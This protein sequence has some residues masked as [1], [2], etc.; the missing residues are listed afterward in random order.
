MSMRGLRSTA[1]A[2][3]CLVALQC[4]PA[5]ADEPRARS[6]LV[7]D[8]FELASVA[9]AAILSS[10]RSAVRARSGAPISVYIENLD[11]AR[12]GGA[13]FTDAVQAYFREKYEERPIGTVVAIGSA[14]LELALHLRAQLWVDTPVIF[15]AVE[16]STLRR[17][18]LPSNV[19]GATIS[20]PLGDAVAV[21]RAVAPGWGH[22]A[23]VRDPPQRQVSRPDL[24]AQ[25]D[26]IATQLELIDLTG[27]RMAEVKHRIAALPSD[28]AI[29]YIGLTLD[30]DNIAYTSYEALAA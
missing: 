7:I 14:A 29:I 26:Q 22:M 16:E 2:I 19:T 17:M 23:V 27:W 12:F 21:A 28:A 20:A 5:L 10:F 8:Q 6:V 15:A 25:L 24:N 30:G 13:Q 18:A 3:L 9:S 11:L 1:G 4:S